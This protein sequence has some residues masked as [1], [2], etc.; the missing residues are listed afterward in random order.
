M[1]INQQLADSFKLIC[2]Q[3]VYY[4]VKCIPVRQ[5]QRRL[6]LVK[7]DEIGDY[8][9]MRNLLQ[10][11]KDSAGYGGHRITLIGNRNWR[12]LFDASDASVADEVIWLDRILFRRNM[13][14]RFSVLLRVRRAGFSDAVN[15]VGSRSFRT[16]DLLVA[17][18]TSSNN[19][20]MQSAGEPSPRMERLLT[21]ARI[22]QR[23]AY[24][25]GADLFDGIRNARFIESMLGPVA[26]V[27]DTGA[28]VVDAAVAGVSSI[29]L[30]GCLS[31]VRPEWSL[32]AAYFVVV[33]GSGNPNKWWPTESF[34][35]T[36]LH[37]ARRYELTPVIC[38]GAADRKVTT[39]LH[40]ALDGP[41]ID[42]TGRTSLP[43]LLS[44]LRMACFLISIDT[45][46]VHLA[47]AVGCPVFGLF[48]G[49]HFG[50][51]SPY[52][53][54]L[55]PHFFSIYP[56]ETDEKIAAG[57]LIPEDVPMGLMSRIPPEKVIRRI[58]K[59]IDHVLYRSLVR[60]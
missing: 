27:V 55:A 9:L 45:G 36:C 43:E 40:A 59:E 52:P 41:A 50:R 1:S 60:Q 42:L 25:G 13:L 20:A 16:D 48:S 7:T 53:A 4:T 10:R 2:Y 28:G 5:K 6:L 21:P 32:P 17:V 57:K 34:A 44:V 33:P 24:A 54:A 31:E 22:Y 37:V 30:D 35:R 56:D 51:F 19:I 39:P 38:G 8:M 58:E 18:S 14:Y 15:L 46:A 23:L 26:G 3:L 49:L 29:R 12:Q 47:A 11:F